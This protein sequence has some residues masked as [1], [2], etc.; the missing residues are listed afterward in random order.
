MVTN[1]SILQ[2]TQYSITRCRKKLRNLE[3]V[4]VF[5]TVGKREVWY[6]ATRSDSYVV[7]HIRKSTGVNQYIIE[8]DVA[9][10]PDIELCR[11]VPIDIELKNL[12]VFSYNTHHNKKYAA[13]AKYNVKYNVL[14]DLIRAHRGKYWYDFCRG[15]VWVK[16]EEDVGEVKQ[17]LD[18]LLALR[19]LA[20]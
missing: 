6:E 15:T 2:L 20:A 8:S 7:A 12:R 3:C 5:D 10:L 17:E 9:S 4:G 18:N 11:H 1:D 13:Q 16:N 19:A 14:S